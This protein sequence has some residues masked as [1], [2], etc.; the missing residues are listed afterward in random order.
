MKQPID[1]ALGVAETLHKEAAVLI[2]VDFPLP[3]TALHLLGP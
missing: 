2:E 3:R 1:Y